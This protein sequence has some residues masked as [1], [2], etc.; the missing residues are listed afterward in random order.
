VRATALSA[1]LVAVL[2]VALFAAGT[3]PAAA[4]PPP[5]PNPSDAQLEAGRAAAA[6]RAG[7][8]GVLTNRLAELD[9]RRLT[10]QAETELALELANKATIDLETAQEQAAA[11]T[12][13]AEQAATEAAAAG[14][15]IEVARGKVDAFASGSYQQGST[16]GSM[17]AFFGAHGPDELLARAHFLNAIGGSQLD[18]LDNLERA[19]AVQANKDS[20]ARQALEVA[21][22]KQA[23]A[24]EAKR[25]ADAAHLAAQR[26]TQELVAQVGR[27]DAERA[28]VEQQ[29]VAAQAT[30]TG[31]QGQRQRYQEWLVA[32]QREDEERA[33]A[34][35]AAAAAAATGGAASG[36][37]STVIARALSQQ[38]VSYAWG[39]G[40][41]NGPTRGIRDG[42][43]AD[44]FGDYDKIGFDCSG[45]M[46]YAFAGVGIRLP[47]YSGYQA[48]AGRRVPASQMRPG[49]LLFWATGGRIHHVALYLGD[50]MMVEA[51]YS[52]ARVRVAP[53]RHA[54]LVPMVTRLL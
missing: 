34:A 26:A 25:Q 2:V 51:P 53:V 22:A 21:R 1:V 45:L 18:A 37:V 49:D 9:A 10:M 5:P 16:L 47:H 20:A 39:G 6:A 23:A 24:E 28:G 30:V 12:R 19:R 42:G 14:R 50:G 38:G 29:L 41:A 52:G 17:S 13:L 8:V 35:A 40:N 4:V 27:L 7:E 32:K 43:V 3:G 54:G 46:I 33:R 11:A 31:L 44:L 15:A 36:G 48:L